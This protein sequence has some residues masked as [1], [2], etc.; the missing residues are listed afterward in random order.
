[1]TEQ[2]KPDLTKRAAYAAFLVRA[3]G[4]YHKAGELLYPDSDYLAMRCAVEWQFDDTVKAEYERLLKE[5]EDLPNKVDL[6]RN[7]WAKMDGMQ[8]DDYLKAAKLYAEISGFIEKPA[9]VQ[10]NNKNTV[11]IPKMI[12][13]PNFSPEEWQAQ[14][15][16]QQKESLQNADTR[17]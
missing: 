12:H 3:K 9:P 2:E 15:A 1:M 10:V 5:G 14:A 11:V 13:A 4:D 16:Q 8:G 7:L 17:H 6:Q